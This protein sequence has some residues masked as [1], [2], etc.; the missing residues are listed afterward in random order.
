FREAMMDAKAND[1]VLDST[2]IMELR[3]DLGPGAMRRRRLNDL[4]T[5]PMTTVVWTTPLGLTVVQPYRRLVTRN[6]ATSLQHIAVQDAN[7][8]APVNSQKQK[9]AFPPNFVHS[10]DASHMILSAIECK[11][12]DLVFASV[13]DSYWTH[14]CDVD[15]MN[16]ILR[17]QFVQLHT[18]DIMGS[19]K[20]EFEERY[21]DNKMPVVCWE[22]VTKD[23]FDQGGKIRIRRRGARKQ[24]RQE[25]EK[26]V[27]RELAAHHL[28]LCDEDEAPKALTPEQQQVAVDAAKRREAIVANLSAVDMADVVEID[29]KSDML[30]AMRQ[31]DNIAYTRSLNI[32]HIEKDIRAAKAAHKAKVSELRALAR[33]VSAKGEPRTKADGAA[34]EA[35]PANNKSKEELTKEIEQL[36][37]QLARDISKIEKKY[38]VDFEPQTIIVYPEDTPDLYRRVTEM[39]K[40]GE[41]AGHLVQRTEWVDIKFDDLPEHGDFKIEEVLSSPYFFS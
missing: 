39:I 18:R 6:V 4:A 5:K 11:K 14:A 24:I 33:K 25:Q 15:K 10:L 36:K 28:S 23:V 2:Q 19:L 30:A 12:A 8:P 41:L 31:A 34:K 40:E 38:E 20:S 21:K 13:H 17:D 37:A 32:N 29:P 26:M 27:D 3:P 35:E 7:M 1:R 16:L 9:T 22:Y